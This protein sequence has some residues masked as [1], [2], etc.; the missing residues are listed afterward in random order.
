MK[1]LSLSFLLVTCGFAAQVGITVL[2]T[3]DTHSSLTELER[4]GKSNFLQLATLIRQERAK[5]KEAILID[6]GDCVQGSISSSMTSGM[7][8]LEPIMALPYDVWVPG[9]HELDFGVDMFDKYCLT[10]QEKLLC[11]NLHVKNGFEPRAWRII[12]RKGARIAVIG[13]SA[14]YFKHW[15]L[16]QDYAR[17]ECTM[18]LAA[19]KKIMREVTAAKPDAIILAIHQAWFEG[20]DPRGVNEVNAIAAK[21]P[22]LDLIL[23]GHSHRSVPGVR[24]GK[25]TWYVQAGAL[26]QSLGV[27]KMIVDTNKHK[28][29]SINSSLSVVNDKTPEDDELKKSLEPRVEATKAALAADTGITIAKKISHEGKPGSGCE[30]SALIAAAIAESAGADVAFHSKLYDISI[31]AGKLELETLFWLVPYENRI[32]SFEADAEL[33]EKL[34]DEQ[35]KHRNAYRYNGPW[36]MQFSIGQDGAKL[37]KICGKEPEAGRKW[38]V[39]FN[40]HAASG[41]GAFPL[42]QSIVE[43]NEC[44]VRISTTL[45]RE[46]V[47]E[48]LK[49]HQDKLDIEANWIVK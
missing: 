23:G 47:L 10:L 33:L 9:N 44:D 48:Y 38:R 43:K 34:M 24:I 26:A 17:L 45:T 29:M 27:V 22:E 20:K 1:F 12:E 31:P 5:D 2:Q 7:A 19:I 21:F 30:T 35:L 37:L 3:T 49:A 41:S 14:S 15:L 39:A 13:M 25:K 4:K 8:G 18:A 40:S 36:N 11:G 6:C 46:A 28:V 32:V 42:L 16:P